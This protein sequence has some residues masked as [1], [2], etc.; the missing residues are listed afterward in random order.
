MELTPLDLWQPGFSHLLYHNVGSGNSRHRL[1]GVWDRQGRVGRGDVLDNQ[2]A[3]FG[4]AVTAGRWTTRFTVASCP[5]PGRAEK[6]FTEAPLDENYAA[7][8]RIAAMGLEVG[9]VNRGVPLSGDAG[10]TQPVF[11]KHSFE[12]AGE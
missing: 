3:L 9:W 4:S 6:V 8:G 1:F 5:I 11:R 7:I 10:L 12:K 2:S